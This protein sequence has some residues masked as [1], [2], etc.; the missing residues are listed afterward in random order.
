MTAARQQVVRD[1]RDQP[2][3]PYSCD[4]CVAPIHQGHKFRERSAKELVDEIERSYREFGIEFF[5]LWGD[6]VT[7]NVKT[8]TTFC[9]ELIARKLPIHWF[10]NARADNLTD[11]AFVHRLKKAGCWMLALGIETDSEEVRKDMVKRLER[12][13]IE[14]AFTN[15]RSAGIK[16]F[17]FFIFGYPGETL[18]DDGPDGRVCDRAGSGLRQFLSR[19]A[20]SGHGAVRQGACAR[21]AA[22]GAS[23]LVE[24]G[25]LVLPVERQRAERADQ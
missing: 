10:G 21:P 7:L 14:T 19:R 8:F 23:R 9:D 20:V 17:A 13:K 24:D 18:A 15:M 3:L 5:Y 25:V 2:R 11:P 12:K 6:T 4:F 1:R 22:P 16:S